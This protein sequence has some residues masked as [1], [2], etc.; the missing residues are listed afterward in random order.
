MVSEAKRGLIRIAAN[1]TRVFTVVFLGLVTVRL[2]LA[3]T[4]NDGWALIALL[5]STISLTA[6]AQEI[7]RSSLIRE[8][9]EA[10][11]TGS[12][13]RF[14]SVYNAAVVVSAAVVLLCAGLFAVLLVI[15][16]LFEIPP[17]LLSAARWLVISRGIITCTVVLLAAPFNMYKVT[18]RMMAYNGWLIVI[19]SCHVVAAA[20][21]LMIGTGDPGHDV[22]L[23]AISSAG[24]IVVVRFLA[25]AVMLG[26]D[27]R[28]IP[29]PGTATRDAIKSVIHVGGW[30]AAAS[31]AAAM[32]H[33]LSPIIMNLAF[34]LSGNLILGLA[35]QLTVG[36]RRLAVGVTEGVDAV[37][38]RLSTTRTDGAV[39]ALMH[40]STRL[41]GLVTF[42]VAVGVILLAHPVLAVWVGARVDDPTTTLPQAVMLIRIMALGMVARAI[43]DG[44]IRI[45]YGA[46]H[47]TRYA[48]LVI[49]GGVLNP[50]L[51]ISLLW[52]LPAEVRYTAVG[53]SFSA[54]LL[55]IHGGLV[56]LVASRAL[57]ISYA[58]FFSPLLRPLILSVVCSPALMISMWRIHEWT[59]IHLAAA[60]ALYGMVYFVLV[61][62]FVADRS[63]RERVVRAVLSRLPGRRA[64]GLPTSRRPEEPLSD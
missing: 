34:G 11:H 13:E 40:H 18:E 51:A 2:L 9:G 59:L 3:S 45:L 64:G 58:Q 5:G 36:V 14:R 16:P 47:V 22:T 42:P 55:V 48:P 12:K 17:G 44:W 49:L 53:W 33:R 32:H 30:N 52:I 20:L 38:T 43:A 54:V 56:P 6:M 1:Y 31:T 63:E 8:L 35:I 4:G 23:Y 39:R 29:A 15:L 28:L 19:R 10:Y 21:V 46:G 24:L 62:F 27:H 25:V 57:R 61:V 7:V 60:A 41:H 26:L 50:V 37:S